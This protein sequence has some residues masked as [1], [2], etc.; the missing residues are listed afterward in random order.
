MGA[1]IWRRRPTSPFTGATACVLELERY[2]ALVNFKLGGDCFS[3]FLF[4]V[5]EPFALLCLIIQGRDTHDPPLTI[6]RHLGPESLHV[7]IDP[8]I[9]L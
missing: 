4:D 3:E 7:G 9:L 2:V 6:P 1:D 5:D 8:G